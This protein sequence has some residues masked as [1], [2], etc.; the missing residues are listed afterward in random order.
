VLAGRGLSWQADEASE[1]RAG[2]CIVYRP[3]RG[4]H[5]VHAF[6]PLDVLAFGE[7]SDDENVASRASGCRTSEAAWS[8]RCPD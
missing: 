6:E 5:T 4:A 3:G 7:R 2:D 1:I 8:A